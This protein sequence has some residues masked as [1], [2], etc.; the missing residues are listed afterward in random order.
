MQDKSIIL[1]LIRDMFKQTFLCV[2]KAISDSQS[3][4]KA[5]GNSDWDFNFNR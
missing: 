4:R 1:Q 2:G 3:W 5:L